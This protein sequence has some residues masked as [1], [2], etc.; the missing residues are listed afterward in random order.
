LIVAIENAQLQQE[1]GFATGEHVVI[2]PVLESDLKDLAQL[3][4]E[5]PY[6]AEQVPWT[7]Q[8]LKKKFEDKDKPGLWDHENKTYSVVR[9][10]GGV[11]GYLKENSGDN[12]MYWCE[13]HIGDRSSDRNALGTDLVA[14]YLAYKERWHRPRR[15]SFALL[16]LEEQKAQWLTAAGFEQ[17]LVFERAYFHQGQ[18]VALAYFTWCADWALAMRAEQHPVMGEDDPRSE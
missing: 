13:L 7:F 3:L 17:E 4:A 1:R 11:V 15:I 5:N 14:T 12:Q 9:K 16:L 2:R 8:R 6:C 10:R 18:T